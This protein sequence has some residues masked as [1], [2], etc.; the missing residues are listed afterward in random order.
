MKRV[1]VILKGL[2]AAVGV[3]FLFCIVIEIAFQIRYRWLSDIPG[4][5]HISERH[6]LDDIGTPRWEKNSVAWHPP[7][8]EGDPPVR[9]SFN[10]AGIRGPEIG[11]KK[12]TRIIIIGDSVSFCG[13]IPFEESFPFLLQTKLRQHLNDPEIE[14]LNFS[15]GDTNLPE[16]LRNLKHHA[17]DY[18]PDIVIINLYLN[19]L[20]RTQREELQDQKLLFSP[21]RYSHIFGVHL[22]SLEKFLALIRKARIL[23]EVTVEE[24][25]RWIPLFLSKDYQSSEE[26][27]TKLYS[28]AALDW[29]ASWQHER[30]ENAKQYF[31]E[32]LELSKRHS[33]LPFVVIFPAAP[34]LEIPNKFT[35]AFLPQQLASKVLGEQ[36]IPF[37][38]L[39]PLLRQS[40]KDGIF[41]D[42]CHLTVK[43]SHQVA[44]LLFY[45][46]MDL[47]EQ[48]RNRP[49]P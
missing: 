30:W 45:S 16:Y 11:E 37:V 24:R 38:N 3:S 31:Q 14:V 20:V 47:A 36:N 23:H 12:S 28:E 1:K 18:S 6:Y 46:I 19:D 8:S 48:S 39:L 41:Y 22:F 4:Y 21:R 27:W 29:G 10:S 13:A 9:I 32:F 34:Q 33:F 17:L 2:I 35:N 7:I 43:G 26:L 49:L 15:V 5:V 42:Q 40:T 25:F 44:K